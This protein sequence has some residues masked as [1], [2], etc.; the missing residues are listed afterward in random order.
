MGSTPSKK[1]KASQEALPPS[2]RPIST[3]QLENEKADKILKVPEKE[4]DQ[5]IENPPSPLSPPKKM[6]ICN[7]TIS[8][9]Y[10]ILIRLLSFLFTP[11]LYPHP[12][13]QI[14]IPPFHLSSFAPHLIYI[15]K[16]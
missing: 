15:K 13:P 3:R 4:I 16:N 2:S 10:F 12:H 14:P 11:F 8:L 5:K 7:N 6:E 9:L 1:K